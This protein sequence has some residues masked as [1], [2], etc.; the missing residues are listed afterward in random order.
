MKSLVTPLDKS[1]LFP[2]ELTIKV[3][4]TDTAIQKKFFGSELTSLIVSNE[5]MDNIMKIL[6]SPEELALLIKGFTGFF[7]LLGILAASF[8]E[9][10]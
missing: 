2:L 3:S 9:V 5:E 8:L 6:K 7:I 10:S 1:I 4:T